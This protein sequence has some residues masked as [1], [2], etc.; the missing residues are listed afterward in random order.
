MKRTN[1]N[2]SVK[3]VDM[4]VRSEV[5]ETDPNGEVRKGRK[6]ASNIRV[7]TFKVRVEFSPNVH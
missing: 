7:V 5:K 6:R 3:A 1:R 2:A 4:R